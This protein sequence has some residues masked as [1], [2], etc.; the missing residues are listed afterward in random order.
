MKCTIMPSFLPPY[1]LKCNVQ[2]LNSKKS[3]GKVKCTSQTFG[4]RS[5]KR[6]WVECIDTY[7]FASKLLLLFESYLYGSVNQA[8]LKGL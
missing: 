8:T 2:W 3:L 1:E 6:E 7:C 4:F 5:L